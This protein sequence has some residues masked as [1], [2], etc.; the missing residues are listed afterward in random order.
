[1]GSGH[2]RH[3]LGL[4]VLHKGAHFSVVYA[5][6]GHHCHGAHPVAFA[7]PDQQHPAGGPTA[8]MVGVGC[9]HAHI[10]AA[11]VAACSLPE[12]SCKADHSMTTARQVAL[13]DYFAE[14]TL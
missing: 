6:V 14:L 3:T 2:Q 9:A 8:K 5:L 12:R 10:P 11:A 4:G 13:H 7:P 1:M